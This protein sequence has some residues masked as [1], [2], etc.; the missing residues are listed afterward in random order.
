MEKLRERIATWIATGL[1]LAAAA[2]FIFQIY[3]WLRGGVWTDL[4]VGVILIAMGNHDLPQTDWAGVQKAMQWF[5][6]TPLWIDALVAAPIAYFS[7][8][9]ES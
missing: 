6:Q 4:P 9:P 1:A 2:T 5:I 3:M 8:K 7:L